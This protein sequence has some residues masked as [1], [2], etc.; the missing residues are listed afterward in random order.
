[1][2]LYRKDKRNNKD[3][4]KENEIV[5]WRF[6]HVYMTRT[7]GKSKKNI[8]KKHREEVGYIASST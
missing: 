5:Y 7:R 6:S 1:M 2:R 4:K 8:K 3:K